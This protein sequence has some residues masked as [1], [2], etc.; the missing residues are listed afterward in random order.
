[1]TTEEKAHLKKSTSLALLDFSVKSSK[2]AVRAAKD[3]KMPF[4]AMRSLVIRA[5]F[6]YKIY[7]IPKRSDP[8]K[9][10]VIAHP[11]KKLKRLQRWIVK[12]FLTEFKVHSTAQAYEKDRSIATNAA[13]HAENNYLLKMDFKDFFPSIQPMDLISRI[14]DSWDLNEHDHCFL[15]NSLFYADHKTKKVVLSIGAPSSPKVSNIVMY[16]FDKKLSDYCKEK[17]ISYSRYADDL[18]FST[19]TPNILDDC[20]KFVHDLCEKSRSPM[21]RVNTDKT[22]HT[23]KKGHR[24]VTGLVL[25]NEGKVSLGRDK[26]RKIRATLHNYKVGRFNDELKKQE[27]RGW[28]AHAKACDPEFLSSLNEKYNREIAD[29]FSMRISKNYTDIRAILFERLIES[30]KRNKNE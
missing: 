16:E 5:L 17:N 12:N 22:V 2:L 30:N 27:L 14:P 24:R 10:R 21:L 25:S 4:V 19:N 18:T 8:N 26:K 11:S 13:I 7:T 9:R 23:S 3:L 6:R 1:M 29:L 28:L 15:F 20:E